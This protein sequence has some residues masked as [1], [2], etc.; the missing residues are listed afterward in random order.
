MRASSSNPLS[1]A[2]LQTPQSSSAPT[3]ITIP[4]SMLF[5]ARPGSVVLGW[6]L[7][8]L[9]LKKNSAIF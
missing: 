1:I 4:T 2:R 8:S 9:I 7:T 6:Y 5:G 3:Q